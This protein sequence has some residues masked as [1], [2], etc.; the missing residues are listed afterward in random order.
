MAG[1]DNAMF[2]SEGDREARAF[3]LWLNSLGVDPFV[4]NLF[5]DLQDGIILLQAL[6]KVHFGI[7]DWK[8]VNKRPIKGK[9]KAIEICNYV[10][11]LGKSL[12]FSL[13][14]IQGSDIFDGNKILTLGFVWQLMREH[15]VQVLK[16]LS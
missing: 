12:K 13:V 1:L 10:L 3:A 11:V 4:N 14:G 6:D 9:F 5:D 2:D 16:S 7:V 8:K 15:V